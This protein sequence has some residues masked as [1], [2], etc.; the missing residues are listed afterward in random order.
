MYG[1][2]TIIILEDYPGMGGFKYKDLINSSV[3]SMI[4]YFNVQ[5]YSNYTLESYDTIIKNGYKSEMIILGILWG[6]T[7]KTELK[8]T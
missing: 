2:N 7:Y 5:F 1:A 3:G 4:D 6:E 8:K